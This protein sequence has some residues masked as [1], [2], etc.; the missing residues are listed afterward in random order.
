MYDISKVY[1]EGQCYNREEWYRNLQKKTLQKLVG[2]M[3]WNERA[4]Q[5]LPY[6][7]LQLAH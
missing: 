3:K 7:V 5:K 2:R 6:L 1:A 4:E